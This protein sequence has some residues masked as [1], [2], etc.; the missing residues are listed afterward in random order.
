M[1][2]PACNLGVLFALL[3]VSTARVSVGRWAL[4]APDG[5]SYGWVQVPKQMPASYQGR[6]AFTDDTFK[7]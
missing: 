7:V 4:Q 3:A 5:T 2:I 6:I 1:A